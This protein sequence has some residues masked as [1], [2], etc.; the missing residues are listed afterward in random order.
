MEQPQNTLS[1]IDA[2]ILFYLQEFDRFLHTP[3]P[4]RILFFLLITGAAFLVLLWNISPVLMLRA[5]YGSETALIKLTLRLIKKNSW[6]T[7]RLA[8]RMVRNAFYD[9][10]RLYELSFR[11]GSSSDPIFNQNKTISRLWMNH[12]SFMSSSG[13]IGG[14]SP[15]IAGAARIHRP[16][17]GMNAQEELDNLIGLDEIKKSVQQIADR[18]TLFKKRK[19]AGLPTSPHGLHLVFT[20]N[21]GTGK[22]SVARVIGRLLKEIG[23]LSEGHVVEVSESEL[24]GQYVGET[25]IKSFNKIQ[26]ALGGVLF[27]DEAYSLL[28]ANTN[29][30]GSFSDSA[31]ATIVKYMED[32]RDDLVV[33][34]AGYPDEMKG[35]LDSNPGFRSRFSETIHFPDYAPVELAR[36]FMEMAAAQKYTLEQDVE[37]YIADAME[38]AKKVFTKNFS[39]ARFVRNMFEDSVRFMA[40][41]VALKASPAKDD[42]MLITR[43]DIRMA[44]R[45]ALHDASLKSSSVKN[46]SLVIDR[47]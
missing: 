12:L 46:L 1:E 2:Y 18:T 28:N 37:R 23:Y 27:I 26:Q 6:L 19:S 44:L 15:D 38:E 35:F 24:I 5:Q 20:G 43:A 13:M 31:I 34:V 21:P 4:E 3:S 22:T 41:R 29:D 25:A 39:N 17:N 8:K 47:D 40:S 36:I 33:I 30:G 16:H 14:F 42:L 9:L 11:T 7:R 32:F 10:D 45:K